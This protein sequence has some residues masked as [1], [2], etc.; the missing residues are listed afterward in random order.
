MK[1][2]IWAKVKEFFRILGRNDDVPA[3]S[4]ACV[5]TWLKTELL[6]RG[7]RILGGLPAT[8]ATHVYLDAST[9][10]R[11]ERPLASPFSDSLS[12]SVC[13]ALWRAMW[14]NLLEAF[15]L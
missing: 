9:C 10:I 12:I 6:G 8:P 14:V 4:W 2:C 15:K 3:R 5:H 1:S 11:G 7:K 13:L